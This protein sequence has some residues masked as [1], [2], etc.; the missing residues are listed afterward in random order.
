LRQEL[1]EERFEKFPKASLAVRIYDTEVL[2]LK[3]KLTM[4]LVI[5]SRHVPH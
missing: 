4:T 5:D 2:Y 1:E 3:D